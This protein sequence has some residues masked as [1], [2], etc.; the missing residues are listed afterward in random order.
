[1]SFFVFTTKKRLII[2]SAGAFGRELRD[3]ARDIAAAEGDKCPW[4]FAGFLD[5]RPRILEGKDAKGEIII[6]SPFVYKPDE[7]DFFICGIGNPKVR[8]EYADRIRFKGGKFATLIEPSSRISLSA[9]IGEGSLIGPFCAI[10]CDLSIGPDTMIT[11]HVTVGHDVRI[12]NACHIG[13][14]V[15]LGGEVTLGDVV[16]IHPHATILPGVTL[17]DGCTVGAGAVVTS[18]VAQ[19]TTV[20]GVP[21]RR[22]GS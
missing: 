1:L 2:I 4:K 6:D 15:F 9:S 11:A 8:R 19:G 21:A 10:S 13:A 5:D 16:T 20:F 14:F 3:I 7:N 17:H 22:V 12:G 18:D